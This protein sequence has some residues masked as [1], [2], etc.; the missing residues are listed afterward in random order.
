MTRLITLLMATTVI[1]AAAAPAFYAFAA[2][3]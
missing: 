3:A 1:V 2:L